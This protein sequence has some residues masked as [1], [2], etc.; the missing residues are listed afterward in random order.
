MVVESLDSCTHWFPGGTKEL[1]ATVPVWAS[2]EA[3]LETLIEF[4]EVS[5]SMATL[6]SQ[7]N[8][9]DA[10]IETSLKKVTNQFRER[11]LRWN[12][13]LPQVN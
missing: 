8:E 11:Q 7:P 3:K 4:V 1:K 5:Q 13:V 2:V 12:T 9:V 10:D 6:V